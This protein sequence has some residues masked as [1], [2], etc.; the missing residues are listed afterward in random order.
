MAGTCLVPVTDA[1]HH[2][3]WELRTMTGAR[4]D[5]K[6]IGS[7]GVDQTTRITRHHA[8]GLAE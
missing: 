5:G 3:P 1:L 2:W 6:R 8:V 7:G 4:T